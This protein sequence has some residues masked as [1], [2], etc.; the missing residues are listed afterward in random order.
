LECDNLDAYLNEVNITI[1]SK[2][3]FDARETVVVVDPDGRKVEL[4]KSI[5]CSTKS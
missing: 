1:A 2:Y 3:A 5:K 4:N